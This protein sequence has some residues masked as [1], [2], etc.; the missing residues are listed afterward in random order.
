MSESIA[1]VGRRHRGRKTSQEA[2]SRYSIT[3]IVIEIYCYRDNKAVSCRILEGAAP[4]SL[5]C[6][7]A[8]GFESSHDGMD[9]HLGVFLC[10]LWAANL[11]LHI[12]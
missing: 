8:A 6:S 10:I 2:K 11:A 9:R 1:L 4:T 12:V 7:L 3:V 5:S